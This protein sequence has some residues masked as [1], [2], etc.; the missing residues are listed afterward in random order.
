MML[1]G[2]DGVAA[3]GVIMYVNCRRRCSSTYPWEQVSG[4]L[5]LAETDRLRLLQ[6]HHLNE[7]QP[8]SFRA[9]QL[10]AAPLVSV[11]V[12]YDPELAAMTLHGFRIYA[13][14]FLVRVNVRLGVLHGA[15]QQGIGAHQRRARVRNVTLC[16][17]SCGA[18]TGCGAPSSWRRRARSC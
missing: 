12:G 16:C 9:S 2:A 4:E 5:S 13:V 17:P 10:L 3:Y 11:F 6:N 1:A 7:P 8:L 15:Q 18:S 14:A